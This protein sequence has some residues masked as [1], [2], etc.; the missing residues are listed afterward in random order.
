[1]DFVS[2]KVTQFSSWKDT[3]LSLFTLRNTQQN[4]KIRMHDN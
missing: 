1:M 4:W 3:E 2:V